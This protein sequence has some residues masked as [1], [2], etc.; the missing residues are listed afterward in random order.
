MKYKSYEEPAWDNRRIEIRKGSFRYI[1]YNG[2]SD[3][4]TKGRYTQS[5][6]YTKSA[7]TWSAKD[8]NTLLGYAL[9]GADVI[10]VDCE[11]RGVADIVAIVF[12]KMRAAGREKDV[13]TLKKLQPRVWTLEA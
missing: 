3:V 12:E 5:G 7:W 1:S 4:A 2:L 6:N 11:P 13:E 10:T 9:H 8:I